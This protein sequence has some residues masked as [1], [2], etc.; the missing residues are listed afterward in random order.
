MA[1][2][3]GMIKKDTH[4]LWMIHRTV[5]GRSHFSAHAPHVTHSIITLPSI[6]K[7]LKTVSWERA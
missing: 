2:W 4:N 1:E 5:H 7:M 3:F 6:Q